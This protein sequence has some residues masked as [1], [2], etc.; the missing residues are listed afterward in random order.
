[1]EIWIQQVQKHLL[2]QIMQCWDQTC[3][4][5]K[6]LPLRCN[7]HHQ[8]ICTNTICLWPFP[9]ACQLYAS[10][11]TELSWI[12]ALQPARWADSPAATDKFACQIALYSPSNL[13][14][15]CQLLCYKIFKSDEDKLALL[16]Y[17]PENEAVQLL[18]DND[19]KEVKF[20]KLSWKA[21]ISVHKCFICNIKGGLWTAG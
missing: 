1:M 15:S 8:L 13:H 4:C 10:S 2:P 20:T 19:Q 12:T 6:H 5:L 16:E 17:K 9:N 3:S 18:T 14:P 7:Q 21:F 11:G